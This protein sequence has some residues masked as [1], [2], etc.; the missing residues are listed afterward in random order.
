MSIFFNPFNALDAKH[1]HSRL[2]LHAAE[3]L[4]YPYISLLINNLFCQSVF[5][6]LAL[7]LGVPSQGWP[8]VRRR[9]QP[10]AGHSPLRSSGAIIDKAALLHFTAGPAHSINS[11]LSSGSQGG[12][13]LD[14]G[15]VGRRLAYITIPTTSSNKSKLAYFSAFSGGDRLLP[16]R[17]GY[18]PVHRCFASSWQDSPC[19]CHRRDLGPRLPTNDLT[20]PLAQCNPDDSLEIRTPIHVCCAERR[21][22]SCSPYKAKSTTWRH[23]RFPSL[24]LRRCLHRSHFPPRTFFRGD[25][26]LFGKPRFSRRPRLQGVV[27]K[28]DVSFQRHRDLEAN[29]FIISV[30]VRNPFYFP[31]IN[32][33]APY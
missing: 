3:A 8:A 11:L 29:A 13:A 25:P 6:S 28:E 24:F 17:L 33:H 2:A 32:P 15:P 9:L 4:A 19:R 31:R 22:P 27:P 14:R 16:G 30:R 20:I 10:G 1:F 12:R 7:P 21:K 26:H 5:C 18:A 23:R